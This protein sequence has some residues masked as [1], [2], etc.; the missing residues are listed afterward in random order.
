MATSEDWAN[1]EVVARGLGLA[2]Q[3]HASDIELLSQYKRQSPE[4]WMLPHL[5]RRTDPTQRNTL[6]KLEED[7]LRVSGST[8]VYIY[9]HM[10]YVFICIAKS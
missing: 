8:L 6:A 3:D 5:R 1:F 10:L 9:P 2:L 4:E 7:F